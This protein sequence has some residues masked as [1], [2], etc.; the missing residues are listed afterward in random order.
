[1]WVMIFMRLIRFTNGTDY[2]TALF[3]GPWLINQ[4][5]LTVQCRKQTFVCAED[6]IKS[7]PVWVRI[8]DLPL[9]CF[10]KPILARLGNAIG[11][12]LRV[13]QTTFI[14]SWEVCKNMCGG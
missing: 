2:E 4:S 1:M 9:H 8:Q 5:Y 3:G 14:A 12:T 7:I 11:H 10:V 13:D 6:S